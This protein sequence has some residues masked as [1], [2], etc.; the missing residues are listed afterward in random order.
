[1]YQLLDFFFENLVVNLE[2]LVGLLVYC[3]PNK[4][5]YIINRVTEER[6]IQQ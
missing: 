1:M 3:N 5:H 4:Q 2:N 6:N